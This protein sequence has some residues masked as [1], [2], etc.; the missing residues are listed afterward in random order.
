MCKSIKLEKLTWVEA[1]KKLKENIVIMIP[2]GARTKE[3][4]PHL[5]LNNDWII[6]E[7]LAERVAREVEV[8]VMPTI[9]YGYYPSFL[10]YHG[11]VSLKL[12]TFKELIK[13]ICISMNGYGLKKFYILNTG[14]S[15]I[16]G[17]NIASEELDKLGIVLK[18]TNIL[19]SDRLIEKKLSEQEGGTHADEMETSMMLY[20]EPNIVDMSKAEKDYNPKNGRGLTRNPSKK[21]AGAYSS[22]GIFGDA[23]LATREKGKAAVE[24]RIKY[25]VKELQE[26]IKKK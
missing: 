10:E 4:G 12:E 9:Q 8:I 25:I 15:T 26:F 13:D 11:S 1:E 14:I 7:Y 17:L 3:H 18:Y 2:L 19:E 16:E 23:T 24:A 21:E 6:A 20:I 22:T 5:P